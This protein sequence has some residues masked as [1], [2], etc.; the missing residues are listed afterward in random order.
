MALAPISLFGLDSTL[1]NQA[2]FSTGILPSRMLK[3]LRFT[4]TKM[5]IWMLC[6]TSVLPPALSVQEALIY[7]LYSSFSPI[8]S[9]EQKCTQEYQSLLCCRN[10][11]QLRPV[12]SIHLLLRLSARAPPLLF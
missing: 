2:V 12:L 11:T 7:S 1:Q 10:V 6:A 4:G 9:T 5:K 8:A 3:Y